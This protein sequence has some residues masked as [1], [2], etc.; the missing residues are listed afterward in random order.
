MD[1][2]TGKIYIN[3][4]DEEILQKQLR[5]LKD[6]EYDEMKNVSEEERPVILALRDYIKSRAENGRHNI[7]VQEKVAFR[8]GFQAAKKTYA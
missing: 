8:L 1:Q 4:G 3:P 6:G 7:S 5:M 2:K